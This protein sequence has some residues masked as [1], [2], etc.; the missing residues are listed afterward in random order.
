M[1]IKSLWSEEEMMRLSIL[2]LDQGEQEF[3]ALIVRWD[4][5]YSK[6]SVG[7]CL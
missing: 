1:T 3:L 2:A 6:V 5:S 4:R 7:F